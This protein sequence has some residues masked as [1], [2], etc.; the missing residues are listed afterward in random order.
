MDIADRIACWQTQ[1]LETNEIN[2]SWAILTLEGRSLLSSK[3]H[4][5]ISDEFI[6]K[7]IE[8]GNFYFD[9]LPDWTQQV[10]I[11]GEIPQRLEKERNG[12]FVHTALN[13]IN[14]KEIINYVRS[15]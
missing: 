6:A 2:Y 15:Q 14:L 9:H 7:L 5:S 11:L 4:D 13:H 1:N 8:N 3:N 12:N 10:L